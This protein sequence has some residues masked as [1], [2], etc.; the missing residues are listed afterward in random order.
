MQMS[1]PSKF[2]VATDNYGP[3]IA[4]ISKGEVF[5]YN[6]IHARSKK[7]RYMNSTGIISLYRSILELNTEIR[8][9][10]IIPLAYI[11]E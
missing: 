2:I 5:T 6:D 8:N 1:I 10:N 9:K 7:I 11:E 3:T 4:N